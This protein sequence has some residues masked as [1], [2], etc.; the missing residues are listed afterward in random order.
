M[1]KINWIYIT[2]LAFGAGILGTLS[3]NFFQKNKAQADFPSNVLQHQNNF[4]KVSNMNTGVGSVSF[5]EASKTSTPT[6]VFIKTSSQATIN[7]NP[8]SWFFDPYSS[9]SQTVTSSGSGV[10]ISKDGYIVTNNHVIAGAEKI[11]VILNQRKKEFAAKLIGADPSTDLALLKI[12]AAD[13]A[14][15]EFANSDNVQIGE[16]VIAV[17]NPFNLT[18][19]VTAGIVSAKGRNINIVDNQFPIESFIQTDAAINPG[20]SGGALINLEGKL[21]GI[22]TAIASNTGSYNGYGFAIPANIVNKIV[23]DFIEF[24]KVQRGFTGME[25]EDIDSKI[26]EQHSIAVDN[27]VYVNSL[28]EDGPAAEA[29]IAI[30]DVITAIDG[31]KVNSKALYDESLAYYRPGDKIEVE[32]NRKGSIKKL[33]VGLLSEENTLKLLRKNTSNSA[34]LG[35]DFTP[36]SAAEQKKMGINGIKVTGLKRGVMSNF[37]I[38]EGFIITKFNGVSYSDANKLIEAIKNRNGKVNIEG[39]GADGG[40]RHLSFYGY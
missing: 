18:S 8:F 37:G 16:W 11:V 19:T 1:K 31:K 6:V 15:I 24:G 30:G 39:Y 4:Q 32:I 17:G 36:L 35:A 38:T 33:K 12:D 10:I 3:A 25:V 26:Q 5:I 34:E 28:V 40:R 23:K 27:G 20:N 29:G 9:R 2:L 21:I 22:N 14:A 7:S 13:L